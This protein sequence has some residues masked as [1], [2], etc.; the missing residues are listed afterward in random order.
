LDELVSAI[1]ETERTF[2]VS[3]AERRQLLATGW[4]KAVDQFLEEG[5]LDSAKEESLANFRDRF[6]LT[7]NELNKNGA[8]TKTAKAIVLRD[9][10]AGEIP[11]TMRINGTPP[12]N[13]QKGG[14]IVWL[15]SASKYLEDKTR[16]QYVGRSAGVSVRVMKGVYYRT[17]A[18]RGHTVEHTERVHV[19]TGWVF[20][21][22]K[23]IYFAGPKKSLRLPYDKIVSFQPFSDG[24]GVMRDAA[25]AK[26]QA[27]ITGDGWFTY[28]LVSN[29]AKL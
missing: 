29:L 1:A 23:N 7:Q 4:E 26:L 5:M 22:N 12:V 11:P 10:A 18:F 21:T 6:K 27:F 19:D 3:P 24:V 15:F 14:Q 28:N 8:L 2:H 13:L 20:V 9:V 16:R 25:T 17:G